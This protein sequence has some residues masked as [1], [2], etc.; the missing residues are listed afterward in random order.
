M[1]YEVMTDDNPDAMPLG[2]SMVSRH[3]TLSRAM[4]AQEAE[5]REFAQSPYATGG[6]YLARVI[7][8]RDGTGVG[9]RVGGCDECGWDD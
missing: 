3:S 5:A 9:H 8:H 1:Y 7:V 4:S 2:T 6:S